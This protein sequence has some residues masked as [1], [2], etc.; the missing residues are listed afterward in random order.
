MKK[1]WLTILSII[2]LGCLIGCHKTAMTDIDKERT[3]YVKNT[4]LDYGI[5]M[6]LLGG[7]RNECYSYERQIGK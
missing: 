2:F 1:I 5:G 3:S 4:L 6:D 7:K